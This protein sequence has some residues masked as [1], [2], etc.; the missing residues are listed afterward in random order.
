MSINSFQQRSVQEGHKKQ[1]PNELTCRICGNLMKD[2]VLVPCC[3][4]SFCKECTYGISKFI[5]IFPTLV[6]M[7]CALF[8]TTASVLLLYI[9]VLC[10]GCKDWIHPSN[11]ILLC[12]VFLFAYV[13]AWETW[14]SKQDM[15]SGLRVMVMVEREKH[16]WN[17]GGKSRQEEET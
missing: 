1:K 7:T 9:V 14:D 8:A 13:M 12:F 5:I 4:K 17:D 16:V 10:I 15:D 3:G 2:A 11:D 6:I